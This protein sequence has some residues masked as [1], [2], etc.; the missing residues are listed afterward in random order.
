MLVR[1]NFIIIGI[2]SPLAPFGK[3][4]RG[5]FGHFGSPAGA[6]FSAPNCGKSVDSYIFDSENFL[7]TFR[8]WPSPLTPSLSPGCGGEGRVRGKISNIF[9]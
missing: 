2:K 3:G 8:S 4:G 5:D 7:L 6:S 9:G 1:M